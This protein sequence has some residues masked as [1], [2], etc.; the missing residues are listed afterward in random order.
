MERCGW[1]H[2][3][4]KNKTGSANG[5]LLAIDS[6]SSHFTDDEGIAPVPPYE[7]IGRGRRGFMGGCQYN[8]GFLLL[9]SRPGYATERETPRFDKV[10]ASGHVIRPPRPRRETIP[11]FEYARDRIWNEL[12]LLYPGRINS[13][14][15][16]PEEEG[17]RHALM[18]MAGYW[19]HKLPDGQTIRSYAIDRLMRVN[20]SLACPRLQAGIRKIF[21]DPKIQPVTE[22]EVLAEHNALRE[23]ITGAAKGAV[24]SCKMDPL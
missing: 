6:I 11:A 12:Q 21:S 14:A 2:S 10:N 3:A 8:R 19:N 23:A 15:S 4:Y 17:A 1:G 13:S 24:A 7:G 18:S 9:I 22:A 5:T 16:R 20:A